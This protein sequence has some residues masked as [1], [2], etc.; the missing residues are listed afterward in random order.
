M[1]NIHL[2]SKNDS[3]SH[4]YPIF[5][6]SSMHSPTS[7]K[8]SAILLVC[9]FLA[10]LLT[11][12]RAQSSVERENADFESYTKALF[13]E[14]VK[15]NS[16]SLHYTLKNPNAY[17]ISDPAVSLGS[18]TTDTDA[19]CA[20]LEN[21]KAYLSSFQADKLS[22]ENR[23]T[24]NILSDYFDLSQKL[25]PYTLYTE[26]LAPL[27][28]T[29]SQLPVVLSEYQ[30]YDISDV[31]TYL[32]LL[33]KVPSYFD[34]VLKFEQARADR[35]LFMSGDSL[36]AL[37]SECRAFVEMGTDNY[38][39]SSFE[40]R[41]NALE[42]STTEASRLQDSNP[43]D[44]KSFDKKTYI[45]KNA[46]HIKKYIFPAY[47][48]LAE[49][50][51]KLRDKTTE[52]QGLSSLPGG[53]TYYELLVKSDTGSERSIV[54]LQDMTRRQIMEDFG[55]L[56]KAVA[57]AGYPGESSSGEADTSGKS[58]DSSGESTA[59][60]ASDF[61]SAQ[62]IQFEDSNPMSILTFLQGKIQNSFP[63]LPDADVQVKYVSESMEKYLSPA[64]YMIPA[65][66]NYKD[67]VIYVNSGQ[68]T[69]DLTL[70]TTLAHEGYPGHLYQ[71][72]YY[73]SRSP[74]PIRCLLDFGG[75]TEGWATYC[76]M[77]SYYY[78]PIPRETAVIMQKNTSILLGL[79]ALA[80]MG[81]HY[82]GWSLDD[83]VTFF[84][85]YGI[86]DADTIKNIYDLI[87]QD[88]ANYLKYYVGYLEFLE[89]KKEAIDAWG[90]EFSQKRFHKAV[91]DVGPAPFW[92][93]EEEIFEK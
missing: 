40:D 74:D 82:D 33:T 75:Y 69:D 31:D 92:I 78:A 24:C 54:K 58:A 81:I 22:K 16:I 85:S 44:S 11:A 63:A 34:A 48:H 72:V 36:D 17:G 88:P 29:Q 84:Q 23:L 20:S 76:E 50:L 3:A 1:S 86:G 9:A 70:F 41:I 21:A 19:V 71:N 45:R 68:M 39:Y 87:V 57:S 18:F 32:E 62:G 65:I 15:G 25:A 89:L 42:D 35:E 67:N 51:S 66:D 37:L 13:C 8:R 6:R 56:Q 10:L 2:T 77:L 47:K 60:P 14:E 27:T 55:A 93:I 64:F 80:D 61:Y 46:D 79:Y 30:F 4:R 90:D 26:P 28:G 7:R 83:T 53:K 91:L 38:L 43:Q 52:R 5:K 12:C 73:M 59:S 49:G